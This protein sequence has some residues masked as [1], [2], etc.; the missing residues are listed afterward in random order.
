MTE[1]F[2]MTCRHTGMTPQINAVTGAPECTDNPRLERG[3]IKV[4][5][6]NSANE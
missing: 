1:E 3:V 5:T 4:G 2:E 6:A